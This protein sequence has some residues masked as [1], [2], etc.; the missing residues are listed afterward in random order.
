MGEMNAT[1]NCVLAPPKLGHA[2]DTVVGFRELIHTWQ[3]TRLAEDE[4]CRNDV[5]S[6]VIECLKKTEKFRSDTKSTVDS[7]ISILKKYFSEAN[8][9]RQASTNAQMARIRELHDSMHTERNHIHEELLAKI[10]EE[11]KEMSV[12]QMAGLECS[13]QAYA[14][15][16]I[17][18][19]EERLREIK[20]R[21]YSK[22]YHTARN[23]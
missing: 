22:R 16:D 15:R 14:E 23:F 12:S 18:R 5:D 13:L 20:L 1:K 17:S 19:K 2:P 8:E 21:K 7:S 3:R 4:Q 9:K 10:Q 11:L 6:V